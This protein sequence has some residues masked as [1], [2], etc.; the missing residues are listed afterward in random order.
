MIDYKANFQT[1]GTNF[2]GT[3]AINVSTP[4]AGDG[5][6]FKAL[7]PNDQWGARQAIMN[8]AGLTPNAVSESYTNSQFLTA[9][10]RSL[11]PAGTVFLSHTQQDPATLGYRFLPLEGQ[12]ILR[13][14][15]ADLDAAVYVGNTRNPT[16]EYYYRADDAGGVTRNITGAYL[17]LADMRGVF[18]RGDDPTAVIDPDGVTRGANFPNF[19]NYSM[20]TH[21]HEVDSSSNSWNAVAQRK[22]DTGTTWDGFEAIDSASSLQLRANENIVKVSGPNPTVLHN[23]DETRAANIAVKFWIRY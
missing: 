1:D 12:G 4:G 9:L 7:M 8:Y 20:Q 2:P 6:E 14:N 3:Q 18:V 10:T 19:Q 21:L 11:S 17:I 5:T 16:A 15:Y 13:A 23:L 22:F